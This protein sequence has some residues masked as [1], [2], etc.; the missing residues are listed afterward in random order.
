MFITVNGVYHHLTTRKSRL[1]ALSAPASFK[2]TSIK[3]PVG[4]GDRCCPVVEGGKWGSAAPLGVGVVLQQLDDVAQP[5]P[6]L[7]RAA[8][9]GEHAEEVRVRH[10]LAADV[11]EQVG[12]VG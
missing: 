7:R 5:V 9:V 2:Q 6:Q 12:V 4:P 1:E 10:P 11:G 3:Q 8:H